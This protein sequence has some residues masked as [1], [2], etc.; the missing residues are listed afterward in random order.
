MQTSPET[1]ELF[2]AISKAQ[3]EF[4]SLPFNRVN[5]HFKSKYADLTATLDMARGPLTKHGLCLIQSVSFNDN[6]YFVTTQI[7]H[8]S[9]QWISESLKLLVQK[10]DMQGLGSAITYAKRYQ[11]QA[12][13][14]LSGDDDDDANAASSPPPP[15]P[16]KTPM[17]PKKTPPPPKEVIDDIHPDDVP[18]IPQEEKPPMSRKQYMYSLI[19]EKGIKHQDAKQIIFRCIG[20]AKMSTDL[21]DDEVEKVINYLLKFKP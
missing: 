20:E 3:S 7:C 13:L 18:E 10:Q 11:A 15:Q 14:G 17:P 5:P 1:N 2:S 12:M 19:T 9:G 6:G 4:K 21:N 16:K 8:S